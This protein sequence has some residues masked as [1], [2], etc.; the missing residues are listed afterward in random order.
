MLQMAKAFKRSC[1]IVL[2]LQ[3]FN[4]RR[5]VKDLSA[6]A[7]DTGKVKLRSFVTLTISC[8][9]E[10]QRWWWASP[11]QIQKLFERTKKREHNVLVLR[12][13]VTYASHAKKTHRLHSQISAIWFNVGHIIVAT[14]LY[15]SSL[16]FVTGLEEVIDLWINYQI[17]NPEVYGGSGH[18]SA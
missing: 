5:V 6:L 18:R 16:H 14:W 17:V 8:R 13:L 15:Q 10:H 4:R 3:V 11:Q 12:E 2:R 9:K 1:P 7:T